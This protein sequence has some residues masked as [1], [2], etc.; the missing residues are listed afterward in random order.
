MDYNYFED[1]VSFTQQWQEYRIPIK[2]FKHRFKGKTMWDGL[3]GSKRM[4][5]AGAYFA[6]I[7]GPSGADR[8]FVSIINW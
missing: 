2:N 3:D 4:V 6:A 5:P 8:D 1:S 7:S